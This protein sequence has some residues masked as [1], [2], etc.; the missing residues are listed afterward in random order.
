MEKLVSQHAVLR[1]T[2]G[3]VSREK[4]GHILSSPGFRRGT[5][6]FQEGVC[7]PFSDSSSCLSMRKMGQDA[8]ALGFGAGIFSSPT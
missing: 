6:L 1:P 2:T 4:I 7:A 8:N 5:F 3:V